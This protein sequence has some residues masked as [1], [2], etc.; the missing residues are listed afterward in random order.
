TLRYE[1]VFPS[2]ERVVYLEGEAFF[3]VARQP[4]RPFRVQVP[5]GVIHVL[6]TA[7]NINSYAA[8]GTLQTAVESGKVAFIPDYSN[9]HTT[10][11]FYL[12]RQQ[13][14]VFHIQENQ[15]SVQ[16]ANTAEDKAWI[17]GTLIFHGNNLAEIA[18]ILERTYGKPV[19]FRNEQV[20]AYRYT[21]IFN[22]TEE[23]ILHILSKT[24]HF[25]YVISDSLIT[26]GE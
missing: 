15:V 18:A 19:Q 21:G 20:K 26:I 24:K 22:N 10:D 9:A 5:H 8:T 3:T 11:T 14:A 6:G 17:N 12:T 2:N 16:A 23:D 25:N 13:K 4:G 7:F 1:N